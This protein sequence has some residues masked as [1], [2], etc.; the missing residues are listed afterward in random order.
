MELVVI[1]WISA[2]CVMYG[3][4]KLM[5]VEKETGLCD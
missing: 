5:P 3:I 4:S 1:S 2:V